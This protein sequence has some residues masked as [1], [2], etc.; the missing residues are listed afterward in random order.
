MNSNIKLSHLFWKNDK[1]PNEINFSAMYVPRLI[2]ID[3]LLNFLFFIIFSCVQ[4]WS[5]EILLFFVLYVNDWGWG[6]HDPSRRQVLSQGMGLGPSGG[7]RTHPPLPLELWG[8]MLI[9]IL[10]FCNDLFMDVLREL[11]L[12]GAWYTKKA[13]SFPVYGIGPQWWITHS[14]PPPPFLVWV[15]FACEPKFLLKIKYINYSLF[16]LW[17]P[18][19]LHPPP[20][21]YAAHFFSPH[22]F[23]MFF[24]NFI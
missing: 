15:L 10:M 12:C 18:L 19:C 9:L 11:G 13:G 20:L 8:I 1:T 17:I 23:C 21:I 7:S 3:H 6:L 24:F 16:T 14:S 5:F 22:F 4:R 2:L